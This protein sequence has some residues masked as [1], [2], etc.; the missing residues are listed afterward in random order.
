[1]NL[2]V[3]ALLA[4]VGIGCIGI[5]LYAIDG[6]LSRDGV[7]STHEVAYAIT[8]AV[9]GVGGLLSALLIDLRRG[10]DKNAKQ[11]TGSLAE[12]RRAIRQLDNHEI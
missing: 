11:L 10:L 5:S 6:G 7:F 8:F 2:L 3:A 1:M 9:L 4:I 12:L